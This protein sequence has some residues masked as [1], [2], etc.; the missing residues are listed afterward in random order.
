MTTLKKALESIGIKSQK[1]GSSSFEKNL[2][3]YPK[4]RLG[5]PVFFYKWILRRRVPKNH[6]A[7]C[8]LCGNITGELYTTEKSK[9]ATEIVKS[10]KIEC[11]T[12]KVCKLCKGE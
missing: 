1:R 7:R 10:K 6:A 2:D 8:C 4:N 5:R 3:V 12:L 11:N 9:E